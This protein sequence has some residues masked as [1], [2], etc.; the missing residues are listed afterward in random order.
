MRHLDR[1]AEVVLNQLASKNICSKHKLGRKVVNLTQDFLDSFICACW[2]CCCSFPRLARWVSWVFSREAIESSQRFLKEY[3][4][5]KS[6]TMQLNSCFLT[7][8]PETL[9]WHTAMSVLIYLKNIRS[10]V[11][12]F[13]LQFK[14]RYV[15]QQNFSSWTVTL[16][17]NTN[18][19]FRSSNT[20]SRPKWFYWE[21]PEICINNLRS[22]KVFPIR[23]P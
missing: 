20:D 13:A 5:C 17:T 18:R 19:A 2:N 4:L 14:F 15:Q 23:R 3:F 11:H 9:V 21:L 10:F 22:V 1:V 12:L 6:K 7:K 8:V 16:S